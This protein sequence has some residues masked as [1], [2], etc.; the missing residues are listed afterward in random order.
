MSKALSEKVMVAKSRDLNGTGVV[1][2][3][4]D[5]A[6]LWPPGLCYPLL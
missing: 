4:Q 2:C 3:G 5:M 1:F 6:M